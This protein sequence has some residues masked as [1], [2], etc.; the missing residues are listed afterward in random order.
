MDFEI[1]LVI[2]VFNEAPGIAGLVGSLN[3]YF[4]GEKFS[5]EVL[6]VDDGSADGSSDLLKKENHAAYTARLIRLAGN[7]GSHA[8]IRAG[9]Y[10]ARGKYTVCLPADLQDPLELA[11]KLRDKC[12]EGYETAF[13]ARNSLPGRSIGTKVYAWLVRRLIY[14]DFPENGFDVVMFDANVREKLNRDIRR[15][16]SLFLQILSMPVKKTFIRYDK[17]NR[18]TGG[19]KWTFSKKIRLA[20]D[21]FFPSKVSAKPEEVFPV[22]EISD[23]KRPEA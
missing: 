13:A 23:M 19:S 21:S 22:A 4:S 11:G 18:K 9:I 1:T 8:A 12:R 17:V 6:F 20:V 14:R 5:A 7:R 16:A 15:H 3:D 2:P 10:H